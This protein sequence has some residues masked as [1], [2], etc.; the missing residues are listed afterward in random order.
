MFSENN[1]DFGGFLHKKGAGT[2]SCEGAAILNNTSLGGGALYAVDG[3]TILWECDI[4]NNFAL[5]GP[6]V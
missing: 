1:A 3:A 2:A 5:A 4:G 6:A